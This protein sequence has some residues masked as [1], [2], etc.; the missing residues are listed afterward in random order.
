MD[1]TASHHFEESPEAADDFG[2][3]AEVRPYYAD[4]KLLPDGRYIGTM[5]LLFHWTIHVDI[6]PMGFWRE[7]YCFATYELAKRALDEW[8]GIGDPDYW[9]KHPDT[10]RRRDPLTGRM[11]YDP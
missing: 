9:H 5:R 4:V 8:D 3:P 6:D 1:L 10:G 11:W 2:F 7:R